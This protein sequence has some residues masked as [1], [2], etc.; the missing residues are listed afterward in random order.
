MQLMAFHF[1][2]IHRL[3]AFHKAW[4]ALLQLSKT[5]SDDANVDDD[6]PTYC[7]KDRENPETADSNL[8]PANG[9]Q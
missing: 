4:H 8:L 5:K 7:I 9:D 1:E 2:V 6:V 3:R